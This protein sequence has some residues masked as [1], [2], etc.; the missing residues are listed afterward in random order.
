[1][2]PGPDLDAEIA[3]KVLG[4]VLVC[5]TETDQYRLRDVNNR[6]W[7]PLPAYSTDETLARQLVNDFVALGCSVLMTDR[8]DGT[9]AVDISAPGSK[10]SIGSV[11][12]TLPHAICTSVLQ[13]SKFS[14]LSR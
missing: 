10:I 14:N 13:F 4:I 3:R 2:L 8:E 7:L 6:K 12:N 1:M 11:G 5:D 9:W